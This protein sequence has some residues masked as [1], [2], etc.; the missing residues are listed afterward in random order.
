MTKH[1][2]FVVIIVNLIATILFFWWLYSQG[3]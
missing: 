3:K 2:E 1:Q